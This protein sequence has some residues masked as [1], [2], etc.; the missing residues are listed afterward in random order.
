MTG[1]M[2]DPWIAPDPS[3]GDELVTIDPRVDADHSIGVLPCPNNPPP[4]EGWRYWRDRVTPALGA[5]ASKILGDFTR[6]PMGA[7]IQTEINGQRVAARVEWH[8]LQGATGKRGCFRGVN[9]M[10]PLEVTE[11]AVDGGSLGPASV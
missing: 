4:P 1:K 6:Y 11:E 3:A 2:T 9:L 5:F 10:Q 7:F 8:D